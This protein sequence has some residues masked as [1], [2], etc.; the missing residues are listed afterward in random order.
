MASLADRRTVS[1]SCHARFSSEDPLASGIKLAGDDMLTARDW[2]T[3]KTSA[4]LIS[5]SACESAV[6]GERPGDEMLGLVRS[7]TFAGARSIVASLWRVD[8]LATY[9][10]MTRFYE[11]ITERGLDKPHALREAQLYLR[12]VRSPSDSPPLK[13]TST[14]WSGDFSHPYYWAPFVLTGTW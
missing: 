9:I 12:G 4:D 8:D 5:L 1:F 11:N 13:G 3:L 2:L 6:S 10:T 14:S 7:M